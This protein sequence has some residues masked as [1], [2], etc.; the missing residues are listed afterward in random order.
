[1]VM[2]WC[3][4]SDLRS[5]HWKLIRSSHSIKVRHPFILVTRKQVF[6][7]SVWRRRKMQQ[8]QP[9][10]EESPTRCVTWSK[11][12]REIYFHDRL[13]LQSTF[14]RHLSHFHQKEKEGSQERESRKETKDEEDQAET[15]RKDISRS[16]PVVENGEIVEVQVLEEGDVFLDG[17][18]PLKTLQN[19]LGIRHYRPEG[20]QRFCTSE[21]YFTKERDQHSVRPFGILEVPRTKLLCQLWRGQCWVLLRLGQTSTSQRLPG[22]TRTHH[23]V[24]LPSSIDQ[25]PVREKS[26]VTLF[27]VSQTLVQFLPVGGSRTPRQSQR[28]DGRR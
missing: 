4:C 23:E 28:L 21:R 8:V 25:I 26:R 19:P 11:F 1:M 6:G 14:T 22:Q 9:S 12:R 27:Q 18:V 13:L 7:L 3:D 17:L 20:V 16:Y 2:K 15:R 10:P 5:H 24:L